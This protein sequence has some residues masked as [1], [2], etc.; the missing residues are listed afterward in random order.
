MKLITSNLIDELVNL[1][2]EAIHICWITAFAM[3][4]GV[5]LVLPELKK[6]YNRG[7]EIQL[8]VGDYLYITQ[9]DALQLLLEQLPNAE[10]RM[11]QS[12]GRS[13]HPKAYLFREESTQHLIVGSSNLSNS[14]LTSGVEWSLLTVDLKTFEQSMD[15][16]HELFYSENTMPIN[17]E[18]LAIYKEKYM[19]ANK[20]TPLST[21]WDD[22]ESTNLMYGMTSH[23]S[24]VKEE[25]GPQTI[26]QPRPAQEL[27]LTA[28]EETLEQG[29]DKALAILATGLGKTYLAAFYAKKFKRV[30]FV[31][32]RVEIL[33]QAK[34]TFEK[35]HPEK[36]TGYF[37]AEEKDMDSDFIFASVYTI[38]QNFH[39]KKFSKDDFDLI[40]IDEFHHA[41]AKTYSRII[42]YF[43][44]KFLL[45]I[46]AT[47]DR[48][49]NQD[50]YSL[51]D[52]N[53]A[54]QI[55]FLDAIAR[56][57]L[58]PFH[59][60]GIKDEIDYSQIRWLGNH[61]DEEELLSEQLQDKVIQKIFNEW[62]QHKQTKTIAF[63]SS[64][65]QASY[66]C[67]YFKSYDV[68]A[69]VLTGQNSRQ[70]RARIREQFETGSLEIIFT[71]DLF[72]EGVDIPAVDTLLFIRPTE[73]ISIFTQQIGRGLRLTEG[74][75]HCIIIDC[76]GNYRNADRKLRIFKP[77][78]KPNEK[79]KLNQVETIPMTD[80]LLHFD[81]DVID[82]LEE[83]SR[84]H[85][86]YRQ[87]I[88]DAYFELKV[89]LGR[90]PTYLEM[91]LNSQI[92]ELNLPREFGSYVG[93]LYEAGELT[94]EETT[95]FKKFNELLNEMEKTVMSKSYKMVV[96]KAMLARGQMDWYRSTNA[97]D[98]APFFQ[99][100]L[101]DKARSHIDPVDENLQKVVSL[102]ERMPMTKWAGSSKGL[103]T[104][105]DKQ[106][107]FEIEVPLEMESILFHWV[108]EICDYRLHRY[109]ERKAK[110]LEN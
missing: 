105:K 97:M 71:V 18:S 85:R 72:N 26:I 101:S 24:I 61:Y 109:F 27:A 100:Y 5:R 93:L 40:V 36:T 63:C 22:A 12:H 57:W 33:Q 67:Q 32:H 58:S 49:D 14:A 107:Q 75:S 51:C 38:S 95:V 46:T 20:V 96:L 4:S 42:E 35:V 45:G 25:S 78:L 10:I 1:C 66:L 73:S 6:A 65:K 110:N 80:C 23:D 21:Q 55:H 34:N 81:L 8:L 91:Y 47:P 48:L 30:L 39:L 56:N 108:E 44:P 59:Y 29:Y 83:M 7:C 82:L 104:F 54:I 70:D 52:G 77:H 62:L 69:A 2:E 60:Y 17:R 74:K 103:A 84:K 79:L 106:F 86:S 92:Q 94:S 43:E 68:Q 9:P 53:V 37:N 89:E 99:Q 28:L 90:R 15:E 11:Y 102:I 64:V 87:Q 98:V 13:F 16:F 3:T 50:V 19:E 41:V 88:I 76:I 31:A